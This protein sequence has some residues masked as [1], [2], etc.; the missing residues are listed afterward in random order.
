[1]FAT[2]MASWPVMLA[3]NADVL[4]RLLGSLRLLLVIAFAHVVF[5]E[6]LLVLLD[7]GEEAP[8]QWKLTPLRGPPSEPQTVSL[9]LPT[10]AGRLLL[11]FI[12]CPS[13]RQYRS[14]F[15]YL[16]ILLQIKQCRHPVHIFQSCIH[17]YQAH[18]P[19]TATVPFSNQHHYPTVLCPDSPPCPHLAQIRHRV[20]I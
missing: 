13:P 11:L 20:L 2:D 18:P 8:L 19:S 14:H 15:L 4:W 17:L 3:L 6:L 5:I 9:V 16:I 10:S 7:S 1:M 12:A